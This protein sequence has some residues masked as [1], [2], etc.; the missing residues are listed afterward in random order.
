MRWHLA[1]DT[2]ERNR[3]QLGVG[4]RRYHVGDAGAG[5]GKANACFSCD[6]RDSLSDEAGRLLMASENV[7]ELYRSSERFIQRQQSAT[8]NTRD[9]ANA[10]AFEQMDDDFRAGKL[11]MASS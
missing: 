8:G 9:D 6:A 10:L 1:R 2:D 11:H 4:K 5:S 3:I 7:F